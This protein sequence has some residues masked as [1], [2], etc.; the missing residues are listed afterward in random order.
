MKVVHVVVLSACVLVVAGCVPER[1]RPGATSSTTVGS[2]D[3]V[4]RA[5]FERAFAFYAKEQWPEAE[6]AFGAFLVRYPNTALSGEASYRH[7]VA[8]NRLGRHAAAK[9]V[10]QRFLERNPTS[11]YVRHATVELGLAEAKLGNTQDAD[12]IL[13]PVIPEL[14]PQERAELDYAL[15]EMADIGAADTGVLDAMRLQAR[16]ANETRGADRDAALAELAR[17]L[18]KEARPDDV[19]RLAES[20]RPSDAAQGLVSAKLARVY[21]HLGDYERAREQAER[22]LADPRNPW[23]RAA[24]EVLERLELRKNVVPRK[25][26]VVL[27]L[28]GRFKAFGGAIA[29]G[30]NFAIR[31]RD[32]I[33]LVFKD[34][35]GEPALAVEAI[36]ELV[37]AGV[38]AILGP[39][40]T[41]EAFPAAIRA[42]ELG[43]PM[44]SL[45]RVE[46]LTATG[47]WVFRN[48]LT[49]SAQGRALARYALERLGVTRAAVFAPDMES[50][51][52][53]TE[54]FW[55]SLESGGGEVRGHELY[56]HDQTTF[57]APIKRLV[58][59]D[60]LGDREGFAAEANRI[61]TTEKDPYRRRK[62]LEDLASKQPP[63]VDFDVLLIPDYWRTATLI[64]PA[65]AVED[66]IT[67]ACDERELERI[68][69]T[70]KRNIRP[71]TL[72]GTAGW[73]NP[74]LVTRGGRFVT[75][76]VFVDGFFAGSER[77]VTRRFVEDFREEY[78][79]QPN[80]LEAQGYDTAR[81][82]RE[83]LRETRPNSREGF[84][85][86]LKGLKRFPGVT[87]ETTFTPDGEADKPLFFLTVTKT[88]EITEMTDVRISAYGEPVAGASP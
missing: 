35:Q 39:V 79:R 4:A 10:L 84:R 85:D 62:A 78:N 9:E 74:N 33:E 7:G 6:R 30:V 23:A 72:L 11:P 45:S 1:L 13:R 47:D 28:S 65:L 14:T 67:N 57:S 86:A 82:V 51:T 31:G 16:R 21:Y 81:I 80:L 44:I 41:N 58:A 8:L 36:E 49:N 54:A 24:R 32:D 15:G 53:V 2:V 46:G 20:L 52:E 43:V 60:N 63:I 70:T 76:S 83:I 38:I 17:L 29:D 73:N 42:Q 12:Q 40:G 59:R 18:D 88:G 22:A 77:E 26:G 56:A 75:C 50:G 61:R 3:Q 37:R 68:R 19:L 87:G 66:I 27:P 64:A 34:S 69:K 25:V 55:A 48:S 71:V 5:E